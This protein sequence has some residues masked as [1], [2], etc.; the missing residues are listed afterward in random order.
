MNR[1]A[2]EIFKKTKKTNKNDLLK[3][4]NRYSLIVNFFM[5]IGCVGYIV[6]YKNY[7]DG[8]QIQLDDFSEKITNPQVSKQDKHFFSYYIGACIILT[9][10][11]INT[12]VRVYHS[13]KKFVKFWIGFTC[14][15]QIF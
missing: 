11:C 15:D 2:K 8:Q 14:L 7:Y 9:Y 6:F 1:I 5:S 10:L 12:Y 4:C 3:Y 13:D